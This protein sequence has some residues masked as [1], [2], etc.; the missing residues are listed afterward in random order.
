MLPFK[1][2][3]VPPLFDGACSQQQCARNLR[4]DRKVEEPPVGRANFVFSFVRQPPQYAAQCRFLT[5]EGKDFD[6]FVY[7]RNGGLHFRMP[8]VIEC[9]S[10]VSC[11]VLAPDPKGVQIEVQLV[12]YTCVTKFKLRFN[13]EG[14]KDRLK[15][16]KELPADN[17]RACNDN[18]AVLALIAKDG[19][20]IAAKSFPVRAATTAKSRQAKAIEVDA[21]E[22]V[23]IVPRAQI[24]PPKSDYHAGNLKFLMEYADRLEISMAA[25]RDVTSKE[26]QSILKRYYQ[27]YGKPCY[28][29]RP[30]ASQNMTCVL[31]YVEESVSE[32]KKKPK[33]VER[34]VEVQ[35]QGNLSMKF[36]D[37]KSGG[38]HSFPQLISSYQLPV[39]INDFVPDGGIYSKKELP[40]KPEENDSAPIEEWS[41]EFP[42]F[43]FDAASLDD[44]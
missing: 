19:N 4:K 5:A 23:T 11:V 22:Q 14:T 42:E 7:D 24:M 28:I 43:S 18:H 38:F 37:F 36:K 26:A 35:G 40:L 25:I 44:I 1:C 21:L 33:I 6:E 31:A 30:S 15:L 16:V 8:A 10:E 20:V 17:F 29:L 12:L 41:L 2:C 32:K 13:S 3:L 9:Q 39:T 34:Q 27:E